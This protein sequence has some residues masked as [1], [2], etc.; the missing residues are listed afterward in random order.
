MLGDNFGQVESATV[1]RTADKE[2][3]ENCAGN[4]K[5]F[6][7][8][9]PRFEVNLETIY[10]SSVTA[11]E[12]MDS[13]TVP[14]V[15]VIARVLD[16]TVKW[17]KGKERMLSIEATSWDALASATAYTLTTGGVWASMDA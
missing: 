2:S 11:P 8:K 14:L 5:A 10:D 3:I 9:N 6:L 1:K 7:L 12:L 4:L 13:I 17:A 16:V 15:G